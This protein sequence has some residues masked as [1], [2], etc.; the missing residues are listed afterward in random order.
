M[1]GV[2]GGGLLFGGVIV[3][4]FFVG[5][6]IGV[7]WNFD[8]VYE[9]GSVIV[10]EVKFKGVYVLLVLI[11]NIYCSVINGCN[12]ECYF[13]DFELIVVLIVGYIKGL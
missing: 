2:W 7:S 8:L 12:F 5:I 9:I 6:F 4:V 11:V 13:E 10:D 1:N 3:V